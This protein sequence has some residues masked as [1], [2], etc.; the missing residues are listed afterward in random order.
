MLGGRSGKPILLGDGTE[1]QHDSEEQD[2]FDHDEED[3]DLETQVSK[4][5]TEREATPG[6]PSE[7]ISAVS[8]TPDNTSN[9]DPF[10]SPSSTNTEKS[11]TSENPKTYQKAAKDSALPEKLE[12]PVEGKA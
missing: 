6:P 1:D 5:H 8:E 10:D 2:M 3:R 9:E 11:L 12:T 7:K 4:G